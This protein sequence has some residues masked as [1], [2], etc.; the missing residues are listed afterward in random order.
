MRSETAEE[1]AKAGAQIV[2]DVSGGLADENMHKTVAKLDL[3]Y[4]LMH[5]R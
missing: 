4:V 1:A 5:W 3:A 2:N